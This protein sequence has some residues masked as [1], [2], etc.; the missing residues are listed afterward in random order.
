MFAQGTFPLLVPNCNAN[1][2]YLVPNYE[3]SSKCASLNPTSETH[4]EIKEKEED[5]DKEI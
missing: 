4:P 2:F 5:K 3:D 1:L